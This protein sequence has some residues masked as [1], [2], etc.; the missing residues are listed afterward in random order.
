MLLQFPTCEIQVVLI[1]PDAITALTTI[2]A[3]LF[4]LTVIAPN[5]LDPSIE[6]IDENKRLDPT[7]QVQPIKRAQC[8]F[9]IY[10]VFDQHFFRGQAQNYD[11]LSYLSNYQT[12][13]NVISPQFVVLLATKAEVM[14]VFDDYARFYQAKLDVFGWT[15][16]FAFSY[17]KQASIKS[18]FDAAETERV[19]RKNDQMGSLVEMSL[20]MC[21]YC[22][23]RGHFLQCSPSGFKNCLAFVFHSF[24]ALTENGEA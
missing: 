16:L 17:E 10:L 21:D 1:E 3:I 12:G 24:L 8:L 20:I 11:Y 13:E 23:Q 2:K 7:V 9:G 18:S 4:L 19:S 14:A 5:K 6:A 15:T 22:P